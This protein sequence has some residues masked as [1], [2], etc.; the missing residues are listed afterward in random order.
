MVSARAIA[1][2]YD[3]ATYILAILFLVGPCLYSGYFRPIKLKI[4]FPIVGNLIVD[5]PPLELY[6]L[7]DFMLGMYKI[8]LN[9]KMGIRK[10]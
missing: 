9:K 4:T 3:P 8:Y 1:L 6:G 7:M 5:V 10:V 2:L